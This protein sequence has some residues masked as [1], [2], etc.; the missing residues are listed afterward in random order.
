[1]IVPSRFCARSPMNYPACTEP[2]SPRLFANCPST[3]KS[4]ETSTRHGWRP[5]KPS[6]CI[7]CCLPSHD[8]ARVLA[9]HELQAPLERARDRL[10]HEALLE[11]LDR[12]LEEA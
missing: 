6:A 1:M 10:A 11:A 3:T 2:R 12:C 4:S 9:E 5:T 8:S 7:G